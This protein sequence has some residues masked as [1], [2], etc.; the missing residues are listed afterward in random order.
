P[1][2][3]H[4]LDYFENSRRA[5]YVQQQY[6]IRNPRRFAGYSE[7]CWGVSASDGPGPAVLQIDGVK[8][9]FYDYRE[10]GVPYGPDDGTIA[11]WAV[12]ASLPFAPEIVLPTLEYFEGI[13]LRNSH[14]YGYK[15]T[16]N[17]T[18]PE[19]R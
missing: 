10:R 13:E 8:R 12:V 16:Y 15:A 17:P 3:Q 9:Y 18:F 7:R 2:R 19:K 4:G 6:A 11:P 5:A 1:M 14:P